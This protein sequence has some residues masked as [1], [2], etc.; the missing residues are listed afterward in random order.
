MSI[1]NPCSAGVRSRAA[2]SPRDREEDGSLS[3]FLGHMFGSLLLNGSRILF[4]ARPT[5]T[6]PKH[7]RR[8]VSRHAR[9]ETELH[10]PGDMG[11]HMWKL[12]M[13]E[14]SLPV[15]SALSSTAGTEIARPA[16]YRKFHGSIGWTRDLTPRRAAPNSTTRWESVSVRQAR[17]ADHIVSCSRVGVDTLN[18]IN[19]GLCE[20]PSCETCRSAAPT[21]GDANLRGRCRTSVRGTRN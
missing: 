11:E 1:D 17:G 4:F 2:G 12:R 6:V 20:D 19:V 15:A 18:P 9:P 8:A 21:G 3:S 13:P 16:P 5:T 14:N 10:E 7:G